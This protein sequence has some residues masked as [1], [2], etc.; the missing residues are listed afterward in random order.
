MTMPCHISDINTCAAQPAPHRSEDSVRGYSQAIGAVLVAVVLIGLALRIPYLATRS[1]WFD[2]AF[3][4]RLSRFPLS[5]IPARAG[6]DNHPPLYFL[7]LKGWTIAFGSAPAALRLLSVL[8]GCLTI[9]GIY[10]FVVEAFPSREPHRARQRGM[11]LFAAAL[12]AVSVFQIR[13]AWEVRMYALGTALAAFSSWA[14]LRALH[15]P[16]RLHPWLLYA[17]FALLFAYTHYYALFTL[18][19][20][21]VFVLGYLM[22]RARG[23]VSVLVRDATF[24]HALIAADVI[25]VGWLP[26]LPLFLRQ[27]AQVQAEFWT[28]P[29]SRWDIP[30]ACWQMFVNPVHGTCSHGEA[31]FAAILCAIVLLAL[32]WRARA[33]EWYVFTATTVPLGL[34]VLVSALDTKVFHLRFLLFAHLFFLVAL[35]VL[36]SRIPSRLERGAIS[37]LLLGGCLGLYVHFMQKLDFSHRP[38]PRATADF[39]VAHRQPKEPII[40]TAAPLYFPILYHLDGRVPCHLLVLEGQPVAHYLG[41]AILTPEDVIREE[42]LPKLTATRVWIVNTDP[43]NG[44]VTPIRLPAGWSLKRMTP[45]PEVYEGRGQAMVLEYEITPGQKPGASQEKKTE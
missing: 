3:S 20:Q 17:A 19:A 10:C 23:K 6:E 32:L 4:W 36:V 22:T 40:V 11:A 27:R 26:W 9:L 15:R 38:G 41:R 24:W 1:F 25:V 43:G 7:L 8:L 12:V 34:S 39:L 18:A 35:A 5:E 45:F 31:L 14:L 29:P 13:W 21:A 33:G 30:N 42:Q 2:E 37:L 44:G 16:G 28:L